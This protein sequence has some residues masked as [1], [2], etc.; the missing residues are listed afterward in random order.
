MKQNGH[1]TERTAP[2][3]AAAGRVSTEP[4]VP[5]DNKHSADHGPHNDTSIRFAP[6]LADQ[7]G[8]SR[9]ICAA[10]ARSMEKLVRSTVTVGKPGPD[11]QLPATGNQTIRLSDL[12]GLYVVLYFYPKDNTPGCTLEGQNFRDQH[13]AFK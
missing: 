4:E 2:C 7:A 10:P 3:N 8:H 13:D 5:Y 12:N 6:R 1:G 11:F 9:T